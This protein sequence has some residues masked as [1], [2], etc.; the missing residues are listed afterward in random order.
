MQVASHNSHFYVLAS[1][2][3]PLGHSVIHD[4][5]SKNL[6]FLQAEHLSFPPAEHTVQLVS[7]GEHKFPLEFPQYPAGQA[8]KHLVSNK[9]LPAAHDEH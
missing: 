7:Q 9:K 1:S 3:F 8:F 2:Y 5:P 6:P 4:V